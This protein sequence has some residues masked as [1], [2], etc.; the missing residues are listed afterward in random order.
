M[1]MSI[2]TKLIML[3]NTFLNPVTLIIIPSSTVFPTER[4]YTTVPRFE[5]DL[6]K[7]GRCRGPELPGCT[8]CDG[9]HSEVESYSKLACYSTQILQ[10]L[11]FPDSSISKKV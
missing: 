11:C 8:G 10:R 9:A 1:Y 4:H 5:Q 2:S 7:F 6:S 3:M